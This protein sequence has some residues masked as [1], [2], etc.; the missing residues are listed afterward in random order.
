MEIKLSNNTKRVAE[1][2]KLLSKNQ[3]KYGVN[4][5]VQLLIKWILITFV[6]APTF[7]SQKSLENAIVVNM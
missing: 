7:G 6:P 1:I 3:K 2:D 4:A 5:I